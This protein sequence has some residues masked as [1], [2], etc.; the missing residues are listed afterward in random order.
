MIRVGIIGYGAA[1]EYYPRELQFFRADNPLR[2]ESDPLVEIAA[3]C[4]ARPEALQRFQEHTGATALYTDYDEM[5]ER[6]RLDVVCVVTT[7]SVRLGPVAAAARHG[8]HVLC[9]KP[10]AT[11]VATCDAMIAACDEAGV[12]LVISHQ[13]RTDPMH[14]HVRRLVRDGLIGELRYL[15]GTGKP[16]RGGNELHNIGTHLI[17]AVAVYG[18][19]AAWVHGYCATAG[20]PS[21]LADAEPGDRGAG[22]AIGDRVDVQIGYQS[23][24]QAQLSF[25]EDASRFHW[26]LIGSQGR[27]YFEN[28]QAWHYDEPV[29]CPTSGHWAPIELPDAGIATDTGFDYGSDAK[30]VIALQGQHS[31]VFMLRELFARMRGELPG[32]E[33]TSSGRRGR[34]AIEVIQGTFVSHLSAQRVS[35]PLAERTSPFA[36]L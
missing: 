10:M 3:G 21:T 13:R 19:P 5:L 22:W 15:R 6:E 12:Q 35:L 8:V 28:A 20:R 14:W 7:A 33:H 2:A 16:R 27:I 32:R 29:W 24:A 25:N 26:E 4:D 1:A 34:D 30:A 9:E 23:G 17:D 31:R 36:G 18:G 11:D